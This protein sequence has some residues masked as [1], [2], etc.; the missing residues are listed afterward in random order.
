MTYEF[1]LD[2]RVEPD[3]EDAYLADITDRWHTPNGTPNGGYTLAVCLQALRHRL[4]LP[5][6]I[7]VSA[8][9]L[10]PAGVGKARITT[11]TV[12]TGRRLATGMA[13]LWQDGK[14]MLR[15]VASFG[16]LDKARGRT[17][18]LGRAPRLPDPETL[19]D[20]LGGLSM[21]GLSLAGRVEYRLAE[22]PGWMRGEPGGKP[23]WEFWMRFRDGRE[24]DALSLPFFVDAM[25]P[26][27]LDIGEASLTVELTVHVRRRPVPGWLA[28][29][30]STRYV[31]DGFHEEDME[32]W[33]S[34]GNLVAQSR[35]LGL[36]LSA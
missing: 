31:M 33:D 8:H 14:E 29:R 28:C 13:S 10:R 18:V 1:D 34:A 20:A 16:D 26:A 22:P 12:K 25:A 5:D 7:A 9:Y 30:V 23:Q 36:L 11:E 19:S 27:V 21:P 32:I 4:P 2:T 17:L 6:P 15:V 3:G 35:Q 24:P